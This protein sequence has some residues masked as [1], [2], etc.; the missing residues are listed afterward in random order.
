MTCKECKHNLVVNHE[1]GDG[2]C[3]LPCAEFTCRRCEWY[4]QDEETQRGYCTLLHEDIENETVEC[5]HFECIGDVQS[6]YE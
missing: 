6:I 2:L 3:T 5:P 1:T 4:V